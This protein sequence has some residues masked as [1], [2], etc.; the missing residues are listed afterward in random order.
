MKKARENIPLLR[1]KLWGSQEKEEASQIS[2]ECLPFSCMHLLIAKTIKQIDHCKT[3]ILKLEI[4]WEYSCCLKCLP[5]C[6]FC[7]YFM[8]NLLHISVQWLHTM[9]TL[10][11]WKSLWHHQWNCLVNMKMEYCYLIFIV[12][13]GKGKYFPLVK[14]GFPEWVSKFYFMHVIFL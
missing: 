11:D 9:Y 3:A 13:M 4:G 6:Y 2:P 8:S 12:K 10:Y 7:A 14:I 1:L 5:T